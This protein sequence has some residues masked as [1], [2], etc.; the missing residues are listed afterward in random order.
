MK[1][2]LPHLLLLMGMSI[3]ILVPLQASEPIT[4]SSGEF[5]LVGELHRPE[6]DGPFPAVIM[7]HGSG[8]SDRTDWGKYRPIMDR[9]IGAGYAVFCWDKPGTRSSQGTLATDGQV[10]NQRAAILLDGIEALRVR[11]DI[12]SDRIG[13]WGLSQGGIVIPMAMTLGADLAFVIL[14]SG[15]GTDGIAQG[16][17]MSAR[18]L[19]CQGE[20]EDVAQ[21][22]EASLSALPRSTTYEEY[23]HHMQTLIDIPG[24]GYRESWIETEDEWAPWDLSEGSTFDP[25]P[26]VGEATI[27]VLILYGEYDHQVDPLQGVAAHAAALRDAGHP[28][29]H[30]LLIEGAGHTFNAVASGCRDRSGRDYVSE[31][32]DLTGTWLSDILSDLD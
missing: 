15:P 26:A 13:A 8:R 2:S 23:L 18:R 14:N 20:S 32:L 5:A 16:A 9:M 11:A 27:P 22:A 19:V 25:V 6:G 31:Y 3:F 4:F 21:V 1:P 17:Y 30:V 10:I 28:Q 7:V 24:L 29:S 12:D